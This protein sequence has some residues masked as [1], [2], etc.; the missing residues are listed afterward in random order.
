MFLIIDNYLPTQI[1]RNGLCAVIRFYGGDIETQNSRGIP[2]RVT[3][4]VCNTIAHN[5][6]VIHQVNFINYVLKFNFNTLI[7]NQFKKKKSMI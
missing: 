3:H 4:V 6:I 5:D 2:E 1:D 7:S